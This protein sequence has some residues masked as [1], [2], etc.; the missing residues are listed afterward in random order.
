MISKQK[1]KIL[2]LSLIFLVS[3][4][5]C[6]A[7]AERLAAGT[8]EAARTPGGESEYTLE[9]SDLPAGEGVGGGD[10][11]EDDDALANPGG[12][13]TAIQKTNMALSLTALVGEAETPT[14]TPS[15]SPTLETATTGTPDMTLTVSGQ[16]YT[17]LAQTLT[18]IVVSS[19]PTSGTP[20][21]GG[22]DTPDGQTQTATVTPQGF[23]PSPIG[24]PCNAFRFVAYAG[25]LSPGSIV[26]PNQQF[27]WYW[28]IQNVG[29]CTWTSSYAM[30][31]Y[32]GFMLNAKSPVYL[33]SG[34]YIEPGEFINLGMVFYTPPQ[35]RTYTSYWMLR[36]GAG[37]TFGG[38]QDF[39]EPLYVEVYVPGQNPPLFTGS[40]ATSP[41]FY[42]STPGP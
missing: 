17:S 9:V 23:T 11:G 31:F 34:T 41:P 13:G 15:P 3:L 16:L 37:N 36:D 12:I 18:A 35:P 5:A 4:P 25:S 38:G 21:P 30:V 19:T 28:R 29:S 1:K 33:P 24:T 2:L 14:S 40:A 22:S 10:S 26:Q 7:L 20:V 39:D 6:D 27:Y 8:L 32:D 42:T